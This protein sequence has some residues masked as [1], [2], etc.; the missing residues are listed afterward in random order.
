MHTNVSSEQMIGEIRFMID[1]YYTPGTTRIGALRLFMEELDF[2]YAEG[3]SD[4]LWS[5]VGR[6][7]TVHEL[8]QATWSWLTRA[9][10]GPL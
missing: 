4:L 10:A 2:A 7:P 9:G 6:E 5:D 1:S 8:A 3:R